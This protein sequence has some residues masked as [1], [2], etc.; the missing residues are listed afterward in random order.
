MKVIATRPASGRSAGL[1]RPEDRLPGLF[2]AMPVPALLADVDLRIRGSN[3]EFGRC[4]P[5][6]AVHA[7]LAIQ[8]LFA[9]DAAERL[10]LA[11]RGQTEADE[12]ATLDDCQ[13]IVMGAAPRAVNVRLSAFG[14]HR[15]LVVEPAADSAR[16]AL[17]EPLWVLREIIESAPLPWTLQSLDFRFVVVNDAYCRMIGY[18]RDE[19]IGR[20]PI[21]LQVPETQGA[22][23]AMRE[24]WQSRRD[25]YAQGLTLVRELVHKN[26]R[27]VPC[28]LLAG[29][30]TDSDG[31]SYVYGVLL[32]LR[33]L[34]RLHGRVRS[35]IDAIEAAFEQ[36]PVGMVLTG[37]DGS[38]LANQAA[39]ELTGEPDDASVAHMMGV[40]GGVASG[41]RDNTVGATSGAGQGFSDGP[42]RPLQIDITTPIGPRNFYR[43]TIRLG[44]PIADD[45]LLTVFSDIT[46][47]VELKQE[48]QSAL[49]Q[50][51]ALLR[52]VSAGLAHVVGEIV[53]QVNREMLR[54]TGREEFELIGQPVDVLFAGAVDWPRLRRRLDEPDEAGRGLRHTVELPSEDGKHWHGVMT[55]QWV[56]PG[57]ADLGILIT[58]AEVSDLIQRSAA[59]EESVEHLRQLI[60]SQPVGHAELRGERVLRANRAL[61]R[62]LGVPVDS[63]AGRSIDEFF[64]DPG[65]VAPLLSAARGGGDRLPPSTEL[66]LPARLGIGKGPR[67][68][69]LVM[70]TRVAGSDEL[71]AIFV[72][73]SQQR[74]LADRAIRDGARFE[75][76][77]ALTADAMMIIE[78][79]AVKFANPRLAELSGVP[80][81]QW[82]GRPIEADWPSCTLDLQDRRQVAHAYERLMQTGGGTTGIVLG[83]SHPMLGHRS[84]RVRLF[85]NPAV[86]RECFVLGEDITESLRLE[87]ER[88]EEAIAQRDRLVGEVHHRIKNNLQ[89]VAGLL[90]QIGSQRPEVAAYLNDASSQ[91]QA[92]A[93]V[94]GLQVRT[95]EV[96]DLRHFIEVVANGSHLYGHSDGIPVHFSESFDRHGWG[97][98]QTEAVP[99]AL[100]LNELLTNAIHHGAKSGLRVEVGA[101]DGGAWINIISEGVLPATFDF[102]RIR[103]GATGL[104]L[105]KSLLPRRGAELSYSMHAENQVLVRLRLMPPSVRAGRLDGPASEAHI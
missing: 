27:R 78:D 42:P 80:V 86:S 48:V 105:V 8:D 11:G 100:I 58:F 64:E 28:R 6:L 82:I 101:D 85:A 102:G 23:R 20:D 55:V 99:M 63:L 30:M 94:H 16:E 103:A 7:G 40:Y 57:R 5:G 22:I 35:Q 62:M 73:L 31:S 36:A 70:L 39:H 53:V 13:M 2:D 68:D 91:I 34:K 84:L 38:V 33:P 49:L 10:A 24:R 75:G 95:G 59:L 17:G 89:G 46:R 47:E 4:F 67:I 87:R 90:Q 1:A 45:R 51:S 88:L 25:E 79:G 71:S 83:I 92:I 43:R 65:S 50:Q 98:P 21:E 56:E 19:L 18:S 9:A 61:G 97:L 37:H 32:D 15:I 93:R 76:F 81:A 3:R 96:V 14:E 77:A 52:C 41:D 44:G 104:G 26:G 74:A 66:V 12:P 54:L 72:D 69:A 29:E 60:E